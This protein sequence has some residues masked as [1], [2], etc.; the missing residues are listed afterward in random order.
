MRIVIDMQSTQTESRFRGIGRYTLSFAQAI[1]RHRGEHE[2]FLALSGLFPDTIEPV[3]AAFDNLLPQENIRVWH[4]PGP[5]EE[6]NPMNDAR[7]EVAE[8]MR[9]EFLASLMPDVIHIGS[10]FEGYADNAVTSIG[11]FDRATPVSVSFY[12]LIPLLNPEHYLKPN[13]RYA[14]YYQ[15]K[16]EHLKM[17]ATLLSI[18][19]FTRQE[20]MAHLYAP[21]I[22]IVNVATAIEPCF[23][24]RQI[25]DAT[26]AQLRQSERP[27]H[28]LYRRRRRTQEP[29]APHS[30]L[31]RLAS[32]AACGPPV[33]ARR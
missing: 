30:G 10:L 18:S 19:E 21:A 32:P 9:E 15:R 16:I 31:R 13:P 17:A 24:P 14:R 25:D 22:R 3:R 11:R 1:V 27:L 20:G 23:C 26:A 29:A 4:A 28:P 5:V 7:R 2:V 12:D 8:L 33:A 6:K